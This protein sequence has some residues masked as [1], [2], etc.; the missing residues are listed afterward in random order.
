LAKAHFTLISEIT[1]ALS[2]EEWEDYFNNIQK[3]HRMNAKIE[4][5]KQ[6]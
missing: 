4:L 1:A 2:K 6:K 3:M 5:S